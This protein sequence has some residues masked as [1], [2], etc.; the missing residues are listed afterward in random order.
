[1]ITAEKSAPWTRLLTW[2][3][4]RR[5]RAAFAGVHCKGLDFLR[6]AEAGVPVVLYG[7]HPGWWDAVL[8]IVISHGIL[9][10]DAYAMMEEKQLARYGFFRK[11]GTFSVVRENP[12]E[13]LRSLQYAAELL[14]G[15]SRFLWLFPQGVI[16]SVDKRP[17][18]FFNGTAR[19]LRD[20]G[21]VIA[22]PVAFRYDFVEKER[23]E[24][25]LA[26]GKPWRI[27]ADERV[28]IPLTTT[29]LE[30]LIEY[31]M[32]VQ[33]EEIMERDF[34]EYELIVPGKRSVNEWWDS[35]RQMK[36]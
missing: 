8:P 12:R 21:D 6:H 7:N 5:L 9:R 31:E 30:Q 1:M 23:P 18:H 13:A 36:R 34:G 20:L 33:R 24:A 22:I 28:D 16:T 2:Y 4:R 19:L 29:L 3:F 32:D 35:L 27:R 14:R 11:I 10:H 15:R 26:F 17:L 25:F